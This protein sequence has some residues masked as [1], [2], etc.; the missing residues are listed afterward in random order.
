MKGNNNMNI[1]CPQ[2]SKKLIRI[3]DFSSYAQGLLLEEAPLFEIES[4]EEQIEG[5]TFLKID[6]SKSIFNDC[7]FHNCN[8]ESSSFVD[9]I[10]QSCDLSN[11]IF[12]G[13]YFERCRFVSCKCIGVEMSD[14]I[15]KH[16][17]FEQ[18]NF[19]Y[20]NFNQTNLT[21]VLFDQIDF[22]EASLVESKLKRFTAVGS[23]FVKN[24]F[25]KTR[26]ATVDFTNNELAAP[27]VS[28][29]PIEL[30]GAIVNMFQAA[31]LIGLWG[32]IVK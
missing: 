16:T 4:Y 21:D 27:I 22:T 25:F 2:I 19:R 5:D 29:P 11:S 26:L 1:L 3:T 17:V 23:K 6:I 32:V 12:T 31:N 13:A 30:K 7:A 28:N 14:T 24:D 8:F 20:S 9:V 15:I 10:F 18:S